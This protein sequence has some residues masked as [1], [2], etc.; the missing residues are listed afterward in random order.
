MGRDS[1]LATNDFYVGRS[2]HAEL[3]LFSIAS[4]E[5]L[6]TLSLETRE[7]MSVVSQL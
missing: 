2:P 4:D 6:S 5:K 1:A 7:H 3:R